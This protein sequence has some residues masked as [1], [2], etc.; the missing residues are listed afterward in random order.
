MRRNLSVEYPGAVY[1]VMNRGDR[2]EPVFQDDKDRRQKGNEL[3]ISRTDPFT[4][5]GVD[6]LDLVLDFTRTF[7]LTAGYQVIVNA[8]WNKG[9]N[10]PQLS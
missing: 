5:T 1:H 4:F 9:W 8:N 10:S 2:R 6:G 3:P 7:L